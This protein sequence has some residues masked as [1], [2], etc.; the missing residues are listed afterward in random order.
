MADPIPPVSRRWLLAA[1]LAA[2]AAPA[3]A[4]A[5]DRSLRPAPRPGVPARAAPAPP[6]PARSAAAAEAIVAEARLGARASVG[7]AVIDLGTGRLLEAAQPDL[8]LPPASVAKAATTLFALDRLGPAFRF[9]TQVIATGPVSGGV[10]RGDLVLDGG[11]DPTLTTDGLADLAAQLRRAGITGVSGRLLLFSGALPPV[12]AIDQR[13]PAHVGYNPAI[14]GLNL[15]YNRVHFEWKRASRGWQVSMDARGDRVIPKVSMARMQVV[16]RSAPL[17]TFSQKNGAEEWTVAAAALGN[18]GSRWLPV[19]QPALYAGEVFR[20]LCAAQ[21]VALPV[22]QVAGNRPGGTVVAVVR[23]AALPAVL[24]DMLRHSTNL[25]AEVVGLTA[26]GAGGLRG[27]AQA[28]N[29][30]LRARHGVEGRF[31][32][33]SGL[34]DASRISAAALARLMAAAASEGRLQPLLRPFA[35]RDAGGRARKDAA[36]Q[37]AA[38]TGTLN[39]V[40]CLAGYASAPGGRPLAFA[41]LSGDLARRDAV[42]PADMERPDGG[43]DWARRSRHMQSRLLERWTTLYA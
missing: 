29:D 36:P 6:P 13:Q 7:Y 39:F 20:T 30:W 43:A 25:T 37:V 26:S 4:R 28:M 24:A 14:S 21:G 38:K 15:N 16:D 27:S 18:G 12:A 42:A 10:V 19:R 11:G 9:R 31:V 40:S 1:A 34:G 2:T 35:L 3:L 33:H 41:I 5:P 22:P 8:A 32:D 17:Y 23:S